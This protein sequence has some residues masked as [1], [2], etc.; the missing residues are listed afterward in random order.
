MF[1]KQERRPEQRSFASEAIDFA[2]DLLSIQ[3]KPPERLPRAILVVVL[4]LVASVVIWA[5]LAQRDLVVVAEG[6]L[7]PQTFSKVV[8]APE[9][10]VIAA[11]L[12]RDGEVVAAGQPVVRI[13]ARLSEADQRSL[14]NDVE[15]WQASLH[16]IEAELAGRPVGRLHAERP[17]IVSAVR[18][19]FDARRQAMLDA[20]AQETANV[21]R[22]SADLGTAEQSLAKIQQVL[23]TY[24]QSADAYEKLR[25]EGFVG[26]LAA[27]EKRREASEK[28]LD[29]KVQSA[30]VDSQR[31]ALRQ[32]QSHLASARSEYRRQLENEQSELLQ[33]LRR[34]K[35]EL[36]KAEVK[37]TLMELRAPQAGVV[38]DLNVAAV[39]AVV[40]AGAPILT[41]VPSQES[42]QGEVL[43][44]NEDVGFVA[45]GQPVQIKV[46]AFPFQRYGLLKGRIALVSADS[47]DPKLNATGQPPNLTYRALVRLETSQLKDS[48]GQALALT[49]GMVIAAEVNL[50]QQSVLSYLLSPIRKTAAEA[51]RER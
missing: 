11:I 41:I 38:K 50:G 49:P 22:A 7:V 45:T 46:A 1:S 17:E 8:Q 28:S 5:A 33:Q 18:S 21:Q 13:D 25:T 10:G 6:R 9:G 27:A 35:E 12:V 51:A 39:G 24:E 34:G 36:I 26:E 37:T 15:T 3:S 14:R 42:L 4:L 47:A 48:E 32:A 23:P 2:P 29:L 44:K 40:A 31:A 20:V 43:L 19:R 30:A 16:F